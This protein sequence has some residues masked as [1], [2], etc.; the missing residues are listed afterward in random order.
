MLDTFLELG[1][2]TRDIA[3]AFEEF[4]TL[5]F[6]AIDVGDI[7]DRG[8]AVVSDGGICVALHENELTGPWLSF[9]R[10]DLKSYVR[11]LRR[12]SIEIEFAN[13]GEQEFHELGFRDPNGQLVTLL[14]ARTFSA[15]GVENVSAS[16]CGTFLEYSI[17]TASIGKSASFWEALGFTTVAE[18]SEPHA[19]RRI[20]G[21]GL[22][23]GLH[24]SLLFRPGLTYSAGQLGARIE[25][26]RAKGHDIRTGAPIVP[27]ER[28]SATL[29]LSV[30]LPI[31]LLEDQAGAD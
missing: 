3:A 28:P 17:A 6:S 12:R 14:E 31:Y 10:P 26:L 21:A 11:A 27:D 7:R 16:T 13:L 1:L 29:R 8:Y 4:R 20:C 18:G 19:W 15:G 22:T 30:D 24:E 5:G 9:V 23:I 25:Y 2:S